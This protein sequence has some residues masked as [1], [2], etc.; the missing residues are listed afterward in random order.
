MLE[1]VD[2]GIADEGVVTVIGVPV[3]TEEYMHWKAMEVLD[4]VKSTHLSVT[5]GAKDNEWRG[6]LHQ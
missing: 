4:N 1:C 6:V 2:V 5:R 3:C